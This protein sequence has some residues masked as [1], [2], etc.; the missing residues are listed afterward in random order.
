MNSF[1]I[2]SYKKNDNT[3]EYIGAANTIN[4]SGWSYLYE[5]GK[6]LTEK[7]QVL[8]LESGEKYALMHAAKCYSLDF[9]YRTRSCGGGRL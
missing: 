1:K 5:N 6:T 9:A 8:G 7:S 3:G 4:R 2:K